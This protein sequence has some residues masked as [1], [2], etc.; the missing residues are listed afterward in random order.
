MASKDGGRL[1]TWLPTL[2][3]NEAQN[4]INWDKGH[5]RN[6]LELNYIN[7]KQNKLLKEK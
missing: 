4:H 6:D 7:F 1:H 5:G 3:L 2:P